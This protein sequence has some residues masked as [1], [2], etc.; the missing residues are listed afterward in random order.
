VAAA[1]TAN[2][3]PGTAMLRSSGLTSCPSPPLETSTSRSVR[4]GN[5]QKNCIATPPP[6]E[7]PTIV[8]LSTPIAEST[9]RMTAAW[10]PSE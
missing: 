1:A 4:C 10:A 9:S 7:C 8:A 6:S 3:M 2:P 5:C